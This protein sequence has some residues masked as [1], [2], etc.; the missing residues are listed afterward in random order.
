VVA[1]VV[2]APVVAFG[3]IGGSGT[4]GVLRRG[5]TSGGV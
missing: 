1:P 4:S 2:A 5:G 3:R